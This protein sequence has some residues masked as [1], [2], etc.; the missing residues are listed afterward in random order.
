[1]KKH[2]VLPHL[3]Q[4]IGLLIALILAHFVYFLSNSTV[5]M[6]A[7]MLIFGSLLAYLGKQ[8]QTILSWSHFDQNYEP[9]S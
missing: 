9:I 7:Y 4:V 3:G 5:L 2:L 6:L 1:M 8:I